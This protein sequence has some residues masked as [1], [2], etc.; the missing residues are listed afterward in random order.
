MSEL[1]EAVAVGIIDEDE[2]ECP[3]DH[4]DEPT[5]VENDRSSLRR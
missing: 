2:V 4:S 1:G 5:T 3:F